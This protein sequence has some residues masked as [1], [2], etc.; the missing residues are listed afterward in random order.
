[1][2]LI[3]TAV[4]LLLFCT[5]ASHAQATQTLQGHIEHQEDLPPL[6]PS[7]RAGSRFDTT[8]LKALTPNNLWYQIPNWMAGTWKTATN[9]DYY[10]YS[11]KTGSK[12]F[13]VDTFNCRSAESWGWQED[14]H[15]QIWEYAHGSYV[16]SVELDD[17]FG[18]DFIKHWDIVDLQPT[19][20]TM[21]ARGIRIRI[22]KQTNLI[23]DSEQ[24]EFIQTYIPFGKNL[25]KVDCSLKVFDENGRPE[26]LVKV[27]A[28]EQ[29]IKPFEQH[30]LYKGQNMRALFREYLITHNLA[31]LLPADKTQIK[32]VSKS[33]LHK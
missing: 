16:A 9:T 1:M 14:R 20:I 27:L 18:V 22:L 32:S 29:K 28:I 6:E 13:T 3:I 12:N 11:Y 33:K 23:V 21:Y 19:S 26:R 30:D 31:H 10:R 25:R 8:K 15:G 5:R 24:A 17:H 4:I 2:H 7:L